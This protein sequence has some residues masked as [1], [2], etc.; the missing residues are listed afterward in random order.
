M[1]SAQA[2]KIMNHDKF[3]SVLNDI[4]DGCFYYFSSFLDLTITSA[5]STEPREP[6]IAKK[7]YVCAMRACDLRGEEEE[8]VSL[9]C[10]YVSMNFVIGIRSSS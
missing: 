7:R 8:S 10:A 1:R 2:I 9:L 3:I 4:L 6:T 5:F